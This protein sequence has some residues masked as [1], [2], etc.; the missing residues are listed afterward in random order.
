MN[1]RVVKPPVFDDVM[2]LADYVVDMCANKLYRPVT[3]LQLQK[4]LFFMNL[5]FCLDMKRCGECGEN[6]YAFLFDEDFEAW[7]Y[8]PVL[9]RVYEKY[10][11]KPTLWTS[12][13]TTENP[14]QATSEPK[15]ISDDEVLVK[16][17]N[18]YIDVFSKKPPFLLVRESHREYGAWDRVTKDKGKFGTIT[19]GD[20]VEDVDK[21]LK[22]ELDYFGVAND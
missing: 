2:T 11:Y 6:E 1:E 10:K 4:M 12:Q 9:K 14:F 21:F 22:K 15:K 3:N 20:I 18:K 17:L 7:Q 19:Q 16:Y 5:F 13:S 8:G